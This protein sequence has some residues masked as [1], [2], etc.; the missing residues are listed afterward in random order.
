MA[1]FRKLR[2]DYRSSFRTSLEARDI[3]LRFRAYFR[4]TWR[5]NPKSDS[6]PPIT[7]DSLARHLIREIASAETVK[8][9]VLDQDRAEDAINA[10][11]CEEISDHAN[12]LFVRGHTRLSISK[13]TRRTAQE[14]S[15]REA[16]IFS[17]FAKEDA[18]LGLLLRRLIDPALGPVWWISRYSNLQLATGDPKDKV[19]SALEAF[20]ILRRALN[21]ASVDRLT[22]PQLLVRRRIDEVFKEI[23]DPESLSIALDIVNSLLNQI[24]RRRTSEN[25]DHPL[26][27]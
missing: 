25:A 6:P 27:P 22:E 19:K 20:A 18:E 12:R 5:P 23:E 4:Y 7:P 17:E 24:I 11:L 26:H 9:R 13:A 1:W 14:R 8:Y 15:S 10:L 21:T 2:F 3:D 16:A